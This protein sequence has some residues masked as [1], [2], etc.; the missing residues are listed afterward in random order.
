[1]TVKWHTETVHGYL[2]ILLTAVRF[3][4]IMQLIFLC[5]LCEVRSKK[6]EPYV[7]L[8]MTQNQHFVFSACLG[9]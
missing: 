1:M 6:Q 2:R 8:L 3:G 4:K 9:Y 5:V 7:F